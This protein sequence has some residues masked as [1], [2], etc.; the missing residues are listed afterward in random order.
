MLKRVLKATVRGSGQGSHAR[1]IYGLSSTK[2][3]S[4]SARGTRIVTDRPRARQGGK[5]DFTSPRVATP[6]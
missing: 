3:Q 4:A 1:L 6:P 5:P 2:K